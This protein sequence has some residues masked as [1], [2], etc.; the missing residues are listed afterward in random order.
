MWKCVTEMY[1]GVWKDCLSVLVFFSNGVFT[2]QLKLRLQST[3]YFSC[4]LIWDLVSLFAIV[5]VVFPIF[6]W[7]LI[8]PPMSGLDGYK[9]LTRLNAIRYSRT[10]QI[11]WN[12]WTVS[13]KETKQCFIFKYSVSRKIYVVK[14]FLNYINTSAKMLISVSVD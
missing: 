9:N 3:S 4:S 7:F 12:K 14:L 2:T 8:P 11:I 10:Q 5:S 1:V 6:S 13:E